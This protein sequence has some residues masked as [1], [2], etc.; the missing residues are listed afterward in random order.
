M[1]SGGRVTTDPLK[2][3]QTL[4]E[5]GSILDAADLLHQV[6]A[7]A[8]ARGR[9]DMLARADDLVA[10]MRAHLE[11]AQLHDFDRSLEGKRVKRQ[12]PPRSPVTSAVFFFGPLALVILVI[13]WILAGSESRTSDLP[14]SAILLIVGAALAGCAGLS[15]GLGHRG[16]TSARVVYGAVGGGLAAGI[17]FVVGGLVW[18]VILF[19]HCPIDIVG[20]W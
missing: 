20:D 3:A 15:V 12:A 8:A 9:V 18:G 13:S 1:V 7:A 14:A 5:E 10:Q 19:S 6:R 2:R 4:F 17:C 11:G 16:R